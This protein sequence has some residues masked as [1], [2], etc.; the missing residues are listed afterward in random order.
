[1]SLAVILCRHETLLFTGGG[2]GGVWNRDHGRNPP[3]NQSAPFPSKARCGRAD[4][5]LQNLIIVLRVIVTLP[6]TP[7]GPPFAR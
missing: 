7:T 6:V 1:M 2:H 5:R 4:S 3:G